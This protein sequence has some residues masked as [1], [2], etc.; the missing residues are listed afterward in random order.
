MF[1]SL[2]AENVSR[3]RGLRGGRVGGRR[4]GSPFRSVHP[5]PLRAEARPTENA[6]KDAGFFA[7]RT[8][9]L[10][11]PSD[12]AGAYV[13]ASAYAILS[14]SSLYDGWLGEPQPTR[15][16]RLPADREPDAETRVGRVACRER[17]GGVLEFYYREAA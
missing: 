12:L 16:D 9:S 13:P 15:R 6:S 17:P 1:N 14:I 11:L 8:N 3:F 2:S 4:V 5:F 7:A 10:S